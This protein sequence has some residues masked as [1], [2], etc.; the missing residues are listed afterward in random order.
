MMRAVAQ[1]PLTDLR[2]LVPGDR[3]S[4]V[5]AGASW[6]NVTR[7]DERGLWGYF[8]TIWTDPESRHPEKFICEYDQFPNEIDPQKV[9]LHDSA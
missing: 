1:E 9:T 2:S 3:F 7:T 8:E 4:F 6:Y 5:G